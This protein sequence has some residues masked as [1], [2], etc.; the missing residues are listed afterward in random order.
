MKITIGNDILVEDMPEEIA[1]R[2]YEDLTVSNPEYAKRR[3]LGKWLGGIEPTL[4][5]MR[6]SGDHSC[7]LPRGYLERLTRFAEEN[8][9]R[10]DI[11]DKRL[12][13]SEIDV[14]FHGS[15][16][17]YQQRAFDSMTKHNDGILVAPCGSGKTAIGIALAAYHRQPALFL[18]HTV[19]LLKQTAEAARRWLRID[20]G[21]IGDGKLDVRPV[22]VGT[23]QTVRKHPELARLFGCVILDECHHCPASTFM[24]T[25]QTF[26][27]T[28][29]YGLT[30]TPTRDDGLS[31][32]MI[33]MLGPVRHTIVRNELYAAD[34]LVVPRVEFI[35]TAFRYPYADD[36]TDMI[37]ALVQD[38]GRNRIIFEVV[39]GLLDDGRRILAL[40]QRVDHC[41][42]FY[43]AMERFRLGA[44]ALAVGARKKERLDGI[45]RITEGNAQ[46]L[47]ATQLADEGLDAPALDAEVL[48]TPQ[49]NGSRAEQRLGRILR[50]LDG[51]RQ[52]VLIDLVDVNVP[53]LRSQAHSRYFGAYRQLSPGSRLPDWLEYKRRVA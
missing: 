21:M 30:A 12:L 40:S 39:R 5:L 36:W 16:R 38:A 22:T 28:F 51:K 45:R 4:T 52:P 13:L 8:T 14:S 29:R 48:L 42:M 49:R 44:A 3:K 10:V 31:S 2:V 26:P 43:E 27:A 50:S 25:L 17:D 24:D 6:R 53:V 18:V 37:T 47:F 9:A 11:V 1:G 20:A 33:A 15:L 35:K 7:S 41:V 46:I 34:V 32:F 23:V 19:D